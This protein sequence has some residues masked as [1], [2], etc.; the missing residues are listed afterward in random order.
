MPTDMPTTSD[1]T[2]HL[3]YWLRY[4]S[5]HVS[6]AFALK[7]ESCGV[8]VA[9]WTIMRELYGDDHRAPS[10][11]AEKLGLTRGAIS[12]LADRL[13]GKGLAAR[14]ASSSD[15]RAQTLSLTPGGRRLV[16]KLAA[17]ADRNDAEF[18]GHLNSKERIAFERVLKEIMRVHGL[19][20]TPVD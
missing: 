6:H 18:F 9:E 16:P 1:L 19:K 5:N 8:T 13:I 7:L 12:K 2:S 17:L 15:R 4:V 10:H 3:G 14:T 20:F 11:V